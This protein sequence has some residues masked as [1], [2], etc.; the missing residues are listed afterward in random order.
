M[1]TMNYSKRAL[2]VAYVIS[3]TAAYPYVTQCHAVNEV[4]YSKIKFQFRA[5]K[6]KMVRF[7]N[8]SIILQDKLI[9]DYTYL[10]GRFRF[11][12]SLFLPLACIQISNFSCP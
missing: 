8:F 3:E 5:L 2:R 6:C 1:V 10:T 4:L 12:Y 9:P 7:V 11:I